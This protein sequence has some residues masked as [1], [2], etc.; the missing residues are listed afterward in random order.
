MGTIKRKPRIVVDAVPSIEPPSG[1]RPKAE[2]TR[3]NFNERNV[4][5]LRVRDQQYFVWDAGTGAVRGLAVLVQ[6]TGTASFMVNYRFP[7]SPRLHYKSLGRV[8]EVTTEEARVAARE[9]RRLAAQGLDPKAEDPRR[10]DKF[11]TVWERYIQED[12]IGDKKNKSASRTRTFVHHAC[13]EWKDRPVATIAYREVGSLLKDIRDGRSGS[14]RPATAARLFAHL[15]D[16]FG[17]CVRERILKASPILGMKTPAKSKRRERFYSSEEL[18]AIW[19]AADRLPKA[20][21]SYVKLVCLF[22][23]RRDELA[24]AR[25]SEFDDQLTLFTVPAERV[26]LKASAKL[27]KRPVYRVPI[28]PLAQRILRGLPRDGELVFPGLNAARVAARIVEA[29]GPKDFLLHVFRHS[30]ATWLENNGHSEWERGLVL[31]HSSGSSVTAGYSHGY[32][33]DLKRGLMQKWADHIAGLVSPA[34][35]ITLLR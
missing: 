35:G 21:G 2:A 30:I 34:E 19:T 3:M 10:S 1:K 22:A 25:W 16:F 15:R 31:N 27:E 7:G 18:K 24:K 9:V 6:P 26:K 14:E 33:L 20:E 13:L 32:A 12:Q 23:L 11:E 29:G 8:G 4:L 28:V 17:W 5:K